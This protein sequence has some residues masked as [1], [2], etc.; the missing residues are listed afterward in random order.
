MMV[1]CATFCGPTQMVSSHAQFFSFLSAVPRE[2]RNSHVCKQNVSRGRNP[3][4]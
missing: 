3:L 4:Y 2:S 1:Q